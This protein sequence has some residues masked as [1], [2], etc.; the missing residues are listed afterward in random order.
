MNEYT[1]KNFD[2]T[3]E[4]Q[5]IV[6]ENVEQQNPEQVEKTAEANINKATENAVANS[7]K[8]VENVTKYAGAETADVESVQQIAN[9]T[10]TEIKKLKRKLSKKFSE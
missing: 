7:T 9:E 6:T 4:V 10:N 3:A 8:S 1:E 5:K 2:N